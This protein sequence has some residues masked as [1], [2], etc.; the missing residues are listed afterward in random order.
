MMKKDDD[1]DFE[2]KTHER[3]KKHE[4]IIIVKMLD[5]FSLSENMSF[6]VLEFADG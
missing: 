1:Y 2:V 4:H 5:N 3:I 6:I